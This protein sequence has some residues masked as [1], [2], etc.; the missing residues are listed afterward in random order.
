MLKLALIVISLIISTST[1]L[2]SHAQT[3][4][5]PNQDPNK[6]LLKKS[7]KRS[8]NW[9]TIINQY[10]SPTIT[11]TTS[12]DPQYI[13][14]PRPA[15]PDQLEPKSTSFILNET[16]ISHLT[17]W[18]FTATKPFADQTENPVFF[19][20][21]LKLTGEVRENLT[22]QNVY[23]V[24][25]KARYLQ[26]RNIP[27]KRTVTTTTIQPQTMNGLEMR[28]SLIGNCLQT[29]VII[30]DQLCTY[31]P[32][33]VTDRNSIEPEF[34][35]PTKVDQTSNV[36]DVVTPASS[37]NMTRP[38]FQSGANGQILGVDLYFPN[39]GAYAGNSQSQETS[40]KR[41][42]ETDAT[43]ATTFSQVRQIIQANHEKAVLA[44]TTRGFTAF[45]NH[46]ENSAV[47]LAL[48]AGSQFLP[49][50]QPDL[51]GSDQPVNTLLN[52]TLFQSAN[53]V[54]LP[55][56]SFTI[57]AAGLGEAKSLTSDITSASQ[58]PSAKYHSLWF[59]LSPVIDR[60]INDGETFYQATGPQSAIRSGGEGGGSS[61]SNISF[62]SSVNQDTFSSANLKNFYT[63]VY[64]NFLRQ[65][66]NF[67]SESIYQEKTRFYPHLS[68]TGNTTGPDDL[69]RYY[70]GVIFSEK[71]MA[72]VGVDYTKNTITG[73]N[74][75]TGAVGYINPDRD[76]YSQIW[77][78]LGKK[79]N[80]NANS[81][82]TFSGGLTYALDQPQEIDDIYSQSQASEIFLRS[83]LKWGIV[84][85]GAIYYF[86]DIL[87]N[88]YDD[89]LAIDFSI[90]PINNL[91]LSAYFAPVDQTTSRSLWG[92]GINWQLQN[93]YNSPTLSLS[94]QNQEYDY[95][96]DSFGN[97]LLVTDNVFTIFLRF[98]SPLNPFGR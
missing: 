7:N 49:D 45:I 52:P 97:D 35:V 92:L 12:N 70:T 24:D 91:E 56:S 34:F 38:G 79:I 16:P 78:R 96:Q 47:N 13:I 46:G 75:Q 26:I 60:T 36:G 14:P 54:R 81:H 6:L 42:E 90:R 48:Q 27:Y 11:N 93:E 88:S 39:T 65:D 37:A 55:S 73:W 41:K 21:I 77:A 89:R 76:Y 44:R 53:N 57:Y 85:V 25:Q 5:E 3:N 61:D 4:V 64:L 80:I 29:D 62:V 72:Y 59:G 50:I 9:S 87:P 40:I 10:K 69:L 15:N 30:T 31:T 58:I 95:G 71:T 28:M 67:V 66:V 18:E 82:I 94:W 2:P 74:L 8:K 84:S 17:K 83:Q 86:G 51:A 32:G 98:G 43:F 33:L 68:F 63:Q 20:G 22:R 1:N 23:T 19:R